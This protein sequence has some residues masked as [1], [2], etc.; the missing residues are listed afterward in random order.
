M[1]QSLCTRFGFDNARIAQHLGLIG[2]TGR[3]DPAIA[4]E[5]VVAAGV[6]VEQRSWCGVDARN[7]HG[8]RL[9]DVL[10]T[11]QPLG[12]QDLAPLLAEQG[13]VGTCSYPPDLVGLG[14]QPAQLVQ[15]RVHPPVGVQPGQQPA[16]RECLVVADAPQLIGDPETLSSCPIWREYLSWLAKRKCLI[17]TID[18]LISDSGDF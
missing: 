7:E 14:R 6:A 11:L 8:E 9:D 2:L 17:N 13:V 12:A 18:G 4:E 5:Q 15:P 16:D 10:C 1:P 3:D